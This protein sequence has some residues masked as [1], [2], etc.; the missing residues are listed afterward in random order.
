MSVGAT[1]ELG[2]RQET[3]WSCVDEVRGVGFVGE[4]VWFVCV[5]IYIL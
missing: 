1:E 2:T 4:C 3:G 5:R